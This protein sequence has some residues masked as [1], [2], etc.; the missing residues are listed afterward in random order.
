MMKKENT[1]I[2]LKRADVQEYLTGPEQRALDAMMDK[3]VRRRAYDGRKPVN[4][5]YV[6]NTDE[7]YAG[8][9]RS[10]ILQGEESKREQDSGMEM[11]N[12]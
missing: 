12:A 10:A 2:V 3:I 11:E 1:H 9:V 5:Y 6:C 8:A 7:P 4:D